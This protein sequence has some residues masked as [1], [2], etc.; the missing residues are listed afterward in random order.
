MLDN[1]LYFRL[2]PTKYFCETPPLYLPFQS[3]SLVAPLTFNTRLDWS[4]LMV[5]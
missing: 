3:Y 4:L 2:R 1:S 5:G